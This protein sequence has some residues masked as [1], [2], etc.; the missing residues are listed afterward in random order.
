MQVKRW[1]RVDQ[2]FLEGVLWAL[3]G[4]ALLQ[5]L[6]HGVRALRGDALEVSG[7]VPEQLLAPTDLVSGP[8]SGTIVVADPTATQYGWAAVPM[9][10]LLVL[11]AVAAWLL[12]GV[13]RGLR[14]GDPFTVASARRPG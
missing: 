1:S 5:V 10:L 4:L 8:L 3:P 14:T 11:A 7:H 9:V 12:L 13:A 2:A 6:V